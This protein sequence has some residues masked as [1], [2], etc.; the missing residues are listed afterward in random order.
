MTS[1]E[2]LESRDRAG[3][4]NRDGDKVCVAIKVEL[5]N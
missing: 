5:I 1:S 4:K 2:E 3:T